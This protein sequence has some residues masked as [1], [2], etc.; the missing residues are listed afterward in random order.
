MEPL[1]LDNEPPIADLAFAHGTELHLLDGI[2]ATVV[3]VKTRLAESVQTN[4]DKD[5]FFHHIRADLTLELF[6]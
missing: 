3:G 2:L 4:L 1:V 5:W 6:F